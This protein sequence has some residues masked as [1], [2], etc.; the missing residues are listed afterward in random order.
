M[1]IK[2][3]RCNSNKPIQPINGPGNTGIKAPTIPVK[4]NKNP[5]INKNM[6]I[7]KA[8]KLQDIKSADS[9]FH[10]VL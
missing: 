5:M 2:L 6:S 8:K 4:T 9:V 7:I 1:G 3:V 10:M